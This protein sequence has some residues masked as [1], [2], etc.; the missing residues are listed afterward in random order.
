MK[1]PVLKVLNKIR[2]C[3][4]SDF[5]G[6]LQ[7][8]VDL[9]PFVGASVFPYTLVELQDRNGLSRIFG[10]KHVA[11]MGFNGGEDVFYC[12]RPSF[13]GLD[14]RLKT[15]FIDEIKGGETLISLMREA[16]EVRGIKDIPI[17]L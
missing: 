1:D 14:Q 4:Q 8:E 2:D 9:P 12:A 15:L 6:K 11:L 17:Y 5:V 3:L 10:K 7:W 13:R 16:G